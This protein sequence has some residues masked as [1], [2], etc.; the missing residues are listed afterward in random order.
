MNKIMLPIGIDSFEELRSEGYYYID[1]TDFIEE[2]LSERFKVNLITRPR[3]FG[4]TLTMSMLADFFDIRKDSKKIFEGLAIAKNKQLCE[5]WMNQYPVLFLTLKDVEGLT[6][7]DAY[8][9]LAATISDICIEHDYLRMSDKIGES[10]RSIFVELQNKTAP[11][12]AV[13][14]SLFILTR[15]LEAHYGKSVILLIDEYDVPLAKANEHGHYKQMLNCIR[16]VLSKALKTNRYLKFTVVTGCLRIAKESIFTGT[17]HF[18]SHTII[19]GMY[20]D[21]FG[22]TPDEVKKL[23]SD[24]EL[25]NCADN[26]KRWYNGYRIGKAEIYCPWDVLNYVND[27][28]HDAEALPK[29]YWKDTSHNDIIRSFIGQENFDVTDQF[30]TLLRG[31]YIKIK[32]SD[33]LTYDLIH[34]SEENLRR[35]YHGMV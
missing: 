19:S 28:R 33:D 16:G 22:F 10:D 21:K 5:V 25:R 4:K 6:F 30:E 7:V 12:A 26:M 32:L 11:K 23:L 8:E 14:N 24:F 2:L 35:Y 27:L 1:K 20:M 13:M 29:S 34:S 18:V 15:M 3:R 17:N 31:N 9:Q